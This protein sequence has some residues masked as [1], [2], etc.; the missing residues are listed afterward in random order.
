METH[1][2]NGH[3]LSEENTRLYRGW[4]ICTVCAYERKRQFYLRNRKPKAVVS[5]EDSFWA[6]VDKTPGQGPNGDCWH[7]TAGKSA[8][9]YGS[10]HHANKMEIAS[11]A[12][13]AIANGEIPAGLIVRHACDNPPCVNP[14]HLLLGTHQDNSD[15]KLSRGRHNSQKKTHCKRG[16]ELA[17]D[18]L[19]LLPKQRRC[20]TCFAMSR[21]KY[22]DK[23]RALRN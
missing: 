14:A 23:C 22:E 1:C 18:N 12:S 5:K 21:K 15:D 3:E 11:R 7:W 17:G 16:H 4:R 9:G 6:R 10:F 2:R 20:R 13:F 8:G 19:E